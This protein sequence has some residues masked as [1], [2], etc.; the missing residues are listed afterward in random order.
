MLFETPIIRVPV[1]LCAS[2]KLPYV[3]QGQA[4]LPARSITPPRDKVSPL[5]FTFPLLT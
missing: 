5:V 2:N 3:P 1:C 4:Q